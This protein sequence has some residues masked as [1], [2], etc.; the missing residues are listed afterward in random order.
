[1]S[2]QQFKILDTCKDTIREIQSY[3]W[4]EKASERGDDKP[5]KKSD[6]LL[7]SIRYAL[8][9]H[10]GKKMSIKIKTDH[11]KEVEMIKRFN[12]SYEKNTGLP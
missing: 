11:E 6:H 10:F 7:D 12:T 5:V 3:V 8:H 2:N 1:M 9:T 4:D